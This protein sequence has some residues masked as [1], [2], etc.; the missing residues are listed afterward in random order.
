[1]DIIIVCGQKMKKEST[2]KKESKDLPSMPPSKGNEEEVK[3]G[4]DWKYWLQTNC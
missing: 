2:D 1:M 3:K 4:K